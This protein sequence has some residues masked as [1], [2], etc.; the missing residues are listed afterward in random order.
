[1]RRFIWENFQAPHTER[2]GFCDSSLFLYATMTFTTIL[3]RH[4]V[5]RAQ[6]RKPTFR[7]HDLKISG[8]KTSKHKSEG[9]FSHI[10]KLLMTRVILA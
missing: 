7:S 3:P 6:K 1:M 10:K 9:N 5:A 2:F 8:K 4:L